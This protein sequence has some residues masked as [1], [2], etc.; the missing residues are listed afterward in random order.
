MSDKSLL[1]GPWVRR[2]ILE[3]VVSALGSDCSR[4]NGEPHSVSCPIPFC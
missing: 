4:T 3:Y 2:F 1:L